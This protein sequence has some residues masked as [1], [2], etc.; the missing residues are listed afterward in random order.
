MGVTSEAE[1]MGPPDS[2]G[3]KAA[4]LAYWL[5]PPRS[6]RN[7]AANQ[8][9]V[10]KYM[11]QEKANHNSVYKGHH[12]MAVSKLPNNVSHFQTFFLSIFIILLFS[13]QHTVN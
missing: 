2:R 11:H 9:P 5:S 13:A 6:T 4:Y 8:N 3:S 10:C 7:S 1:T 12:D